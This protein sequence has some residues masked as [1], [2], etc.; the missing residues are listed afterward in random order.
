MAT[1]S[2]QL[3]QTY[4]TKTNIKTKLS[5]KGLSPTDVFSEYPDLIDKLTNDSDATAT[6]DNLDSGVIAYAKGKKLV[7]KRPTYAVWG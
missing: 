2:S 4:E 3:Q 5:S 6:E 1:I 7:G